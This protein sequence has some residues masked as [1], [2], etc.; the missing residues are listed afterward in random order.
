M[1]TLSELLS[2][3]GRTALVTG[4]SRG[5]GLEL[6]EGL[7][8]AGARVWVT[9]RRE[10]WLG[11]AL[12]H[13]RGAGH[14]AHAATCDVGDPA[15][16]DALLSRI[17]A[18]GH[19]VDVLVNNAGITWAAPPEQMPME[20][21]RQV[22]DVNLTGAFLLA[23]ALSP[24]M[25]EARWGRVINIASIAGLVGTPSGVMDAVGYSTSK[26][27]L[28]GLTRD[29]A[30]KWA[31]DGITVNAIAPGFFRTRMSEP[32][33][34]RHEEQI[35]AATPMGRIGREGELKALAVLLASDGGAFITGQVIPVDGGQSAM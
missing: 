5:I 22:L 27:A 35:V 19:R 10:A 11:P 34:A 29:L 30:V 8:E 23:R 15:S 25:R 33:L 18:E 31:G 7:A 9:A 32:L 26:A 6:A 21:W 17:G 1:A 16:I 28:I 24:A 20:R 2:L 14:D 13:L 3:K 4:G 12:E